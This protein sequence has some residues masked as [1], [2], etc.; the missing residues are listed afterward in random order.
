MNASSPE[1]TSLTELLA[2]ALRAESA[3]LVAND[4]ARLAAAHAHRRH[5]NLLLGVDR[6]LAA[7]PL[8]RIEIANPR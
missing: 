3:A 2:A 5:L 6:R 4:P 8:A 7:T 1:V